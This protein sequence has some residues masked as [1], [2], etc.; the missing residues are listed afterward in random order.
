[1]KRSFLNFFEEDQRNELT[2]AQI[3]SKM[4]KE[5]YAS[6]HKSID[7]AL[8]VYLSHSIYCAMQ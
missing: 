6:M 4:V 3:K 8:Q 2:K 5:A 1:M 7:P